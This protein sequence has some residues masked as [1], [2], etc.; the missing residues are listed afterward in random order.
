MSGPIKLNLDPSRETLRQFSFIALGAFTLLAVLARF[1]LLLF[2]GGLGAARNPLALV[3]LAIG[4]VSALF[5][6]LAPRAN[7]ALFV[8]LSIVSY[9]IGFVVSHVLLALFFFGVF[10]PLGAL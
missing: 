7:W 3:F 10:A 6:L 2:S 5:S 9:P 1:E 8:G 4:G